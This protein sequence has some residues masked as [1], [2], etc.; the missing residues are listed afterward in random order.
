MIHIKPV[1]C[2]LAIQSLVP[3][4]GAVEPDTKSFDASVGIHM[5]CTMRVYFE[6]ASLDQQLASL[7]TGLKS[8]TNGLRIVTVS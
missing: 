5:I 6:Q 8:Q 4:N 2:D 3:D 7:W 1:R